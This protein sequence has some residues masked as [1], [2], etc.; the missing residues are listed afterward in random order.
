MNDDEKMLL[1]RAQE[2][3]S[4]AF[5]RGC[6]TNTEF[7]TIAEQN[8]VSHVK[9]DAPVS[10]FG[11][12]E[13]AER[14]IAVFGSEELC[15]YPAVP[16]VVCLRIGATAPKFAEELS[17]RDYLGALMGLGVRREV[18]G[19]IV[20]QGK[21]A[22]LFCLES[23]AGFI[24]ENCAQ[25]RRTAVSVSPVETLPELLAQEPE[26]TQLVVASQRLDALAAAVWKLS[27]SEAKQLVE[28]GRV[29]INSRLTGDPSVELREGALVSARGYG[30]FR[31]DGAAAE[32][33]K[34][35]LRV[36]LRIY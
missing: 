4:R 27:R 36:V 19:D 34:G 31:F 15:G 18:L 1:K 33:R 22:Y 32:T 9:T 14:R 17:H 21:G 29:F 16:P 8:I 35:R 5:S 6:W 23:I 25:I 24:C 12:W 2:L 7:L 20:P 10:F 28:D 30:R 11:G 13:G 26:A 3:S